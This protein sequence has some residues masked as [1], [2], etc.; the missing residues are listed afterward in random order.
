MSVDLNYRDSGPMLPYAAPIIIAHG[1]F[2]ASTT[3]QPVV[4]EL[5]DTYRVIALDLRNHGESPHTEQMNYPQLAGDIKQLMET[6]SI[7]K[8]TLLGH[9]IGGK[10]VM[11]MAQLFPDCV[12]HLIVVDSAPVAYPDRHAQQISA[13]SQLDLNTLSSRQEVEEALTCGIPDFSAREMLLRN[14]QSQD[15][16]YQWQINL[17]GIQRSLNDLN[18][19]PDELK[20]PN[21]NCAALFIGGENSEYFQKE[22]IKAAH[23]CFPSASIVVMPKASHCLPTEN[24]EQFSNLIAD[25]VSRT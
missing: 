11:A 24:A 7:K 9:H 17:S 12:R 13:M 5:T 16:Q 8:A 4:E 23:D 3:W 6:L 19:F 20:S 14:L 15:G 25:Y 22:H 1:L 18:G 21:S 2:D 10:A